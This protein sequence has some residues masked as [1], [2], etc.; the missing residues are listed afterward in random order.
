MLGQ[1]GYTLTCSVTGA[2]NLSPT[3]TY[4]WTRDIGTTQTQVETNS[5]TL[6]FSPLSLS[7]AGRYTCDVTV[8]SPYLNSDIMA[9]SVPGNSPSVTFQ[10]KLI[11]YAYTS[12]DSIYPLWLCT[13]T[14]P[15]PSFSVTSNPPTPVLDGTNVTVT[16]TVEMGEGV[17]QSD[18]SLLMVDAQLSRD[19]TPLDR[20]GPVISG[21][22]F[23]YTFQVYLFSSNDSGIFNCTATVRPQ[24]TSTYLTGV[25]TQ[26]GVVEIEIG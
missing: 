13:Y 8:S 4:Q 15:N 1:P 24:Q 11:A 21:T 25:G 6:S 23:T 18:L 26:S 14:V 16:C 10:S 5:N 7:D 22:T 19:G 17:S 9:A 2:E 3:I 12:S 20:T